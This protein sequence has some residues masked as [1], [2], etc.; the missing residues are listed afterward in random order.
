VLTKTKG[1]WL[2]L[3]LHASNVPIGAKSYR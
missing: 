3:H 2:I 1:K